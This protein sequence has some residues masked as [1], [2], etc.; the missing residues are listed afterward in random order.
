MIIPCNISVISTLSQQTRLIVVYINRDGDGVVQYVG[1]CD[2]NEMW[3]YPDAMQNSEWLIKFTSSM[4]VLH[5]EITFMT[6]EI[7]EAHQQRRDLV[8]K[9]R[10]HCNVKGIYVSK[11]KQPIICNETLERFDTASDVVKAHQISPSAL[12]NHLNGK[13]GFKTVKGRTYSRI[14]L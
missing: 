9:Y 7:K 13:I 1:L 2:F 10:P 4:S 6:D 3:K 11:Q 8:A 12:S 5:T 14:Y